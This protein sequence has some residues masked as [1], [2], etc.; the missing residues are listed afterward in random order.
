VVLNSV[1]TEDHKIRC[2]DVMNEAGLLAPRCGLPRR[3][4]PLRFPDDEPTQHMTT[5]QSE[6]SHLGFQRFS[7]SR[8]V[9]RLGVGLAARCARPLE[10]C[11]HLPVLARQR[12][13]LVLLYGTHFV[14]TQLM[15][16]VVPH[17]GTRPPESG[18]HLP[19]FACQR[20]ALL[21]CCTTSTA[22][23]HS[24]ARRRRI[25]TCASD[26]QASKAV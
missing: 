16:Y 4:T 24:R 11:L 21:L 6:N 23:M 8:E 1:R 18:L 12:L 10:S 13:A 15:L 22:I 19:G 2:I 17:S 25:S 26:Y 5:P 3:W 9:V 14:A 20:F 7:A